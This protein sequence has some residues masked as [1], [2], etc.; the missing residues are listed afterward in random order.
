[1]GLLAFFCNYIEEVKVVFYYMICREGVI[2]FCSI[3][4]NKI[5]KKKL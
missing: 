5:E 3:I 4:G 2:V 1:M